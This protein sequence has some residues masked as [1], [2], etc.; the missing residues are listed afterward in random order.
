MQMIRAAQP[1]GKAYELRDTQ[2]R[3]LI[4]RVQPTGRKMFYCQ[5][6]RTKR[7]RIGRADLL[8]LTQ[9]RTRC[10]EILGQ[11]AWGEDLSVAPDPKLGDYARGQY[12]EWCLA[13]LK[14]GAMDPDRLV[15]RFVDMLDRRLSKITPEI[16]EAWVLRRLNHGRSPYTLRRDVSVLRSALRKAVR[17]RLIS[18]DPLEGMPAINAPSNERARYLSDPERERLLAALDGSRI[19]G[20][21][22][23]GINTGMRRG[24]LLGLSWADADLDRRLVTVTN[25]SAKSRKVRHIPLNDKAIAALPP[26]GDGRVFSISLS[27]LRGEWGRV[28]KEAEIENFRLHDTRHDFAS[29][30][31]MRGVDLNTVRELLGHSD[32]KMTLRYAHLSPKHRRAAVALL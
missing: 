15:S 31:V 24:E 10:L 12:R 26:A 20:L 23:L 5:A 22:L 21:V 28:L 7:I 25:E 29:Q 2:V 19:K 18:K 16:V 27:T 3:G 6:A 11:S 32:L 8:T 1:R 13:H 30:L 14:S 17:W 4:L 9:A